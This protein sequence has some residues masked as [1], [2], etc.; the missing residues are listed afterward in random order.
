MRILLTNDDGF[1]AP[2]LQALYQRLVANPCYE[3]FIVAPE[4]QR[5]ATGHSITLFDPL[6][7]VEHSL[8]G[9]RLGYSVKG[10]PAD[11]VKLAI[12]GEL[13]PRPDL[14]ISGINCGPNLGTD[15]FYS[16]TVSAALEAVLLGI[17]AIAVSLASFTY[18]NY[19]PAAGAM[20]KLLETVLTHHDKGLLNINIPESEEDDWLGIRVTRLGKAVYE[21]VFEH[22][23]NPHGRKYYWQGG[24]LVKDT[25]LDTDLRAVQD[26]Y[27]SIT[28]MHS[29]LTDYKRVE[30]LKDLIK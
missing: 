21:N 3:V 16:G 29:D 15:V 12:Q 27:I 22:R 6:F 23:V 7:T 19:Q 8:E 18:C 20:V 10:N 14:V 17:P 11:C 25:E 13:I 2:G 5:S 24:V 30:E 26:G 28:P 9:G 1:F 4:S